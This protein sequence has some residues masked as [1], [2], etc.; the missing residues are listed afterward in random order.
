MTNAA[1]RQIMRMM[2]MK[3]I[4]SARSVEDMMIRKV[5]FLFGNGKCIITKEIY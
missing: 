3:E 2:I 1:I 4:S 5:N